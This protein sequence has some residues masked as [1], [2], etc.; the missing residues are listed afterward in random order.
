MLKLGATT[1]YEEYDPS[2]EG[3]EHY[4]MYGHPY[5]KSLCHAWSASPIYL[6]GAY[7]LGV[8]NTG[9]AYDSFEVCPE[10]GDLESFEGTVPVPEG[11]VF[12][13]VEKEKVTVKSD[14]PGGTL[15]LGE[16]RIPI[17]AGEELTVEFE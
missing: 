16:R 14:I 3:A 1:L 4:A 10:R 13:R 11:K 7:R 6:L 5:Q 12:V 17:P 9:I 15:V 8:R 2:M